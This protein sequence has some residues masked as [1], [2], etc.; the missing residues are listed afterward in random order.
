[1]EATIPE[2]YQKLSI[3]KTIELD[4]RKNLEQ[5]NDPF[6][7]IMDGIS[8][9]P[10][11]FTLKLITTFE[12]KPLLSILRQKGYVSHVLHEEGTS[13]VFTYFKKEIDAT[14]F[15][16]TD[17]N[18]N[19]SKKEQTEELLKSYDEKIKTVDVRDLEMPLPMVTILR[20]LEHL[21]KDV[22]LYVNHKK[23]PEFLLPELQERGYKWM[24]EEIE[25]GNVKLLIYK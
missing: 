1:M 14:N 10:D 8:K 3:D 2:F 7:V 24:I 18:T 21:P 16:R 17:V 13:L 15:S 25:E 11:G 4:V 5:G 23:I 12:P 20:E 22:L 9:L 19:P 6:Q